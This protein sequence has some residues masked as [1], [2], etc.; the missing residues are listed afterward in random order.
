MNRAVLLSGGKGLRAGGDIPK[1]YMD[2][3]G[4]MMVIRALRALTEHPEIDSV[5]IVAEEEWRERIAEAAGETC[6]AGVEGFSAPGANRAL[7]ILNALND[8]EAVT[9]EDA[10]L[11]HDAARPF[12]SAELIGSCLHGLGEHEGVMP[13]IP[14]KDTTYVCENGRIK[15]LLDR[16]SLRAGQ[17]PEAFWLKRFKKALEALLPDRILQIN[18]SAEIA[19][20][21]GMDVAV[22]EGDEKNV[23]I[24]TAEDIKKYI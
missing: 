12:V 10:V 8:M 7:S 18:G 23:K 3:G 11:I 1:Q 14:V 16:N 5:R 6:M 9:D 22:I 4:E 15:A 19:V 13:G 17:A 2:M 20:L 21:D 24:T